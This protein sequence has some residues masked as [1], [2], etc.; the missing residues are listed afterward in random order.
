MNELCDDGVKK[1]AY[2]VI[3]Q[4]VNDYKTKYRYSAREFIERG[5]L[6][7]WWLSFLVDDPADSVKAIRYKMAR[8]YPKSKNRNKET[9]NTAG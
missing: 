7:E 6:L 2:A 4:A 8:R 9:A 1:L 3:A 5:D